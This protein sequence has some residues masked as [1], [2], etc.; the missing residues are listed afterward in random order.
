MRKILK[1]CF[2]FLFIGGTRLMG[3]QLPLTN[4]YLV[5]PYLLSPAFS[6]YNENAKV[7]F[8]YRKEWENTMGSP[9]SAFLNTYF[10]VSDRVW[11]GGEIISDQTDISKIFYAHFSYLY[12]L[13]ITANSKI[14]FSLWG[15]MFQNSIN[16]NDVVISDPRDPIIMGNSSL[17]GTALNAGAGL[18]F[19]W[20]EGSIG[21]SSPYLFTNNDAYMIGTENNL[22]VIKPQL[23]GFVTYNFQLDYN[24]SLQPF[25]VYRSIKDSPYIYDL[26][27]RTVYKDDYWAGLTY[28]NQGKI[29]ISL[30]GNLTSDL[31]LNYTYE[32]ATQGLLANP[33]AI[34]EI[35]I[36]FNI[37]LSNRYKSNRWIQMQRAQGYNFN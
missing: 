10:P 8:T 2:I 33:A 17:T 24:W 27:L 4:Q 15:S 34:H 26:S 1:I 28:R 3:Q 29:G 7:F 6:S 14:Y 18:I 35:M 36:G 22:I 19:R 20:K 37:N 25:L 9:R 16:L 31:S 23:I 13:D 12:D 21:L 5:N 30:G 11:L 32:F